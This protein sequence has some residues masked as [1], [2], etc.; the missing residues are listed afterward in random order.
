MV[1]YIYHGHLT[2]GL[3]DFICY[4]SLMAI[5]IYIYIHISFKSLESKIRMM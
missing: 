2:F 4:E 1:S 5:C 3:Q